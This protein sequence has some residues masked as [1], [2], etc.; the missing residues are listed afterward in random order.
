MVSEASYG[1]WGERPEWE[2]AITDIL[3]DAVSGAEEHDMIFDRVNQLCVEHLRGRTLGDLGVLQRY[4][5]VRSAVVQLIA[6]PFYPEEFPYPNLQCI[7]IVSGKPKG[8]WFLV[9]LGHE[10]IAMELARSR[11]SD[12]VNETILARNTGML[13]LPRQA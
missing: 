10:Q 9:G 4:L 6:R 2:S 1:A 8:H 3:A 11:V 5:R 12:E 7:D 13:A